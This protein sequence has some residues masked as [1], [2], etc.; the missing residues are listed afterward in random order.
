MIAAAVTFVV[1]SHAVRVVLQQ[2]AGSLEGLGEK[3]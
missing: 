1:S 3:G 2:V